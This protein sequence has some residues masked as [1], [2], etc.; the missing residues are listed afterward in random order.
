VR[1]EFFDAKRYLKK[2]K[3]IFEASK[4]RKTVNEINKKLKI[5]KNMKDREV[6][7]HHDEEVD[8]EDEG[9]DYAG[10]DL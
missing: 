5:L 1:N 8:E 10:D 4:Y 2:S 7:V 3:K 6:Q 9:E